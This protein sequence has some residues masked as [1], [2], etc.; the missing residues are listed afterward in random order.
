M[1]RGRGR[2]RERERERGRVREGWT[3]S[4]RT[5]YAH[6]IELQWRGPMIKLQWCGPMDGDKCNREQRHAVASPAWLA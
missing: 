6:C 5:L 2:G 3:S 1:G 4:T